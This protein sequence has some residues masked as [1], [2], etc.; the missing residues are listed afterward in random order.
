MGFPCRGRGTL[1][2]LGG[3]G[4][5]GDW[6][7]VEGRSRTMAVKNEPAL[8]DYI[9]VTL[10]CEKVEEEAVMAPHGPN[11]A[12]PESFC[13]ASSKA[14]KEPVIQE[15][16]GIAGHQDETRRPGHRQLEWDTGGYGEKELLGSWEQEYL[17]G[18]SPGGS[19]RT[20]CLVC[21]EKLST[22]SVQAAKEHILGQHPHTLG[23][24]PAEKCNI[25]EAWCDEA[26]WTWADSPPAPG[27]D[28]PKGPAEIEVS[29]DPEE[30]PRHRRRAA[31]PMQLPA[32]SAVELESRKPRGRR[33]AGLQGRAVAK[34]KRG[35]PSCKAS[36]TPEPPDPVPEPDAAP[37]EI[38]LFSDGSFPTGFTFRLFS[39]SR[40][41][42][43]KVRASF[44]AKGC[45]EEGPSQA[46]SPLPASSSG[47]RG[48]L[49]LQVIHL[50]LDDS[51]T[52]SLLQGWPNHPQG[53]KGVGTCDAL[54]LAGREISGA[55]VWRRGAI[56]G[57]VCC[58]PPR[59]FLQFL[60]KY[61]FCW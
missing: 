50:C 8:L 4:P 31:R 45:A 54:R 60:C 37:A 61:L 28:L 7:R 36:V 47:L 3:L 57:V 1:W 58:P 32:P 56:M 12:A 59:L 20:L 49:G 13:L 21:G 25:L 41:E 53:P 17:V 55:M 51:S 44:E 11:P 2:C 48:A 39:K 9:K 5:C 27:S 14:K 40:L 33:W 34:K 16:Q 52:G 38:R 30:Q 19:G 29:L 15:P 26:A 35:R 42:S 23:L 6:S 43:P 10:K 22:H 18:S 46:Q 24:S